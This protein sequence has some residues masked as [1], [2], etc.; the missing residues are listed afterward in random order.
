MGIQFNGN[1]FNYTRYTQFIWG[2]VFSMGMGKQ[3]ICSNSNIFK[4]LQKE[5]SD[6]VLQ[7]NPNSFKT[8]PGWN[9]M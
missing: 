3:N 5:D 6:E 2:N 8:Y 7:A 1:L 9:S 4:A